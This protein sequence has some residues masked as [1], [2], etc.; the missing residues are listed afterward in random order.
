MPRSGP[1][2]GGQGR[3]ASRGGRGRGGRGGGRGRNRNLIASSYGYVYEPGKYSN[4]DDLDDDFQVFG[5]FG[6]VDDPEDNGMTKL[7]KRKILDHRKLL[8]Q[9]EEREMFT[10]NRAKSSMSSFSKTV[11]FTR[12]SAILHPNNDEDKRPVDE[13]SNEGSNTAGSPGDRVLLELSENDSSSTS[14]RVIGIQGTED[15]SLGFYFDS[16][17]E[18][19]D[20]RSIAENSLKSKNE[21]AKQKK[22]KQKK[23][24][25]RGDDIYISSESDDSDS[26]RILFSKGSNYD[27]DLAIMQDYI[28]NMQLDEEDQEAM[29]RFAQDADGNYDDLLD[30]IE[31]EDDDNIYNGAFDHESSDES[32]IEL[33]EDSFKQSLSRA[34]DDV[35]PSLRAGMRSRIAYEEKQAKKIA[36]KEQRLEKRAKKNKDKNKSHVA[37][38]S[39]DL[40]KIDKRIQNFIMDD[41]ITSYQFAPMS[42]H[43]RRQVHLI[44]LAYKLKTHSIGSGAQRMPILQK[45][46]NTFLPTDRR[47]IERFLQQAQSTIDAQSSVLRKH[48][49]DY[50]LTGKNKKDKKGKKKSRDTSSL[51]KPEH[52]SIVGS[53]AR[54]LDESNVGHRMLSAMGWKQGDTLGTANDGLAAPIEVVVRKK[55]T[56]LGS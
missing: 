46:R 32:I 38:L 10:D 4:Y 31:S 28:E 16:T 24:I 51:R 9:N 42:K 13:E 29:Q 26:D 11:V 55:R 44:A 3:G 49:I 19:V 14:D 12:S 5:E 35:P 40:R 30:N 6:A 36:K 52:N 43:C 17:P 54:P 20:D 34:L 15:G 45:T 21:K 41:D 22:K 2:R 48:R 25:I 23:K 47:Y 18:K 37:E 39:V 1:K 27:E 53:G 7:R 56:G 33:D 50:D 8:A